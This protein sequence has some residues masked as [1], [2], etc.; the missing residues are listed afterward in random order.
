[1]LTTRPV[2]AIYQKFGVKP[3][4]HGAETTRY[5]GSSL[6]AE[7][8]LAF[9]RWKKSAR[10]PTVMACRSSSMRRRCCRRARICAS[11]CGKGQIW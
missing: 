9:L 6:R 7:V 2:P 11:I 4:I 5:S 10:L 1:M 8:L 3:I